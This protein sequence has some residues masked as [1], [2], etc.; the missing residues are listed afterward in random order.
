M[1]HIRSQL[2]DSEEGMGNLD[3]WEALGSG[4]SGR[5]LSDAL[6]RA[7]ATGPISTV[8]GSK[9]SAPGVRVQDVS[10]RALVPPVASRLSF[11]ATAADW[12]LAE[13]LHG[14]G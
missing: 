6:H 4:R 12:D 1:K 9:G 8:H 10:P 2:R 3:P 11:P 13:Y 7:G 5:L 14:E